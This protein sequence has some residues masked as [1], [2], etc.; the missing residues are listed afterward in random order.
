MSWST[1]FEDLMPDTIRVQ[2]L[3]GFDGYGT[4]TFG[5]ASTYV[6]RVVRK[7]RLV[8]SFEG[9]EEISTVTAYVA[10]TSTFGPGSQYLLPDGSTFSIAPNLLA[11]EAFPDED[12][13]H[14]TKLMFG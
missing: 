2:D 5:T 10:S 12:G 3:S 1:D 4:A 14:H 9:I 8:R 13:I 6:A 7:Q 11:V